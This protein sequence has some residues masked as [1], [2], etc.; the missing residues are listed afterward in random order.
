MRCKITNQIMDPFMSFGKMPLANG[1]IK[2]NQFNNEF[3]YQMEV[4]FSKKISLFQLNKHPEP[5]NMFNEKYPFYTGSSKFMIN[6]FKNYSNWIKKKFLKSGS[7]LIEIGSNDGTFLN[8]FKNSPDAYREFNNGIESFLQEEK[9]NP[10]YFEH[11]M[12][13]QTANLIVK[14]G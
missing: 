5:E 11:L 6:H 13:A 9:K 4:G 7:K 12:K 14:R 3:F 8:N 2:K 10:R 1:F